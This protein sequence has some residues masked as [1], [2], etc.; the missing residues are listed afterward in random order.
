MLS[1]KIISQDNVKWR[2]MVNY[3]GAKYQDI[4]DIVQNMYLKLAEIELR[5]GNLARLENS[6]G[7]VNTFYIFKILQSEIV[8]LYRIESKIYDHESQFNP[9]ENPDEAEYK[10]QEL[11]GKIKSVIDGMHE[12]D[13]MILELYFVYGHSLRQIEKRTGIT[14]TSVYNTLK[15]AKQHIKKHSKQLYDEYIQQKAETE[16]IA[17][18]GRFNREDNGGNWD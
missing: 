12:Y 17:R 10:Y 9:I 5:D 13:Q 16:T 1:L 4:D 3:L 2:K 15:N 8:N 6:N 11:M 7:G 18:F 14:V